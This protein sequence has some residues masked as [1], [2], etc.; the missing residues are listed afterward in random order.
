[1]THGSTGPHPC[2]GVPTGAV[3][4]IW[5]HILSGSPRSC[6][7]AP[8]HIAAIA[9]C[10]GYTCDWQ[11]QAHRSHLLVRMN[12]GGEV[13]HGH[14][15][16]GAQG[17]APQLHVVPGQRHGSHVAPDTTVAACNNHRTKHTQTHASTRRDTHSGQ[18]G[19]SVT[20][21]A[22]LPAVPG[23]ALTA[24]SRQPQTRSLRQP[25]TRSL[26]RVCTKLPPYRTPTPCCSWYV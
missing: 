13:K 8:A 6:P 17:T 15:G 18:V 2:M 5:A 23:F 21:E 19:S 4:P 12:P 14:V 22:T 24:P 7:H 3:L 10:I 16:Q 20:Q 9:P 26:H 1:M 11:Q 25:Q